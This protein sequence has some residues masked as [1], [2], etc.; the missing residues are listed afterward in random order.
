MLISLSLP[1]KTPRPLLFPTTQSSPRFVLLSTR[2]LVLSHLGSIALS[3]QNFGGL[4]Q[5]ATKKPLSEGVTSSCGHYSVF[6]PSTGNL[7]PASTRAR[8]VTQCSQCLSS[9]LLVLPCNSL[10]SARLHPI[11][12]PIPV[13][14]I[15]H[16]EIT[17][18]D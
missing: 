15:L 6:R 16:R 8:P 11:E 9:N 14:R 17:G 1:Q 4:L 7:I 2:A 5:D 3:H 18:R 10:S 13:Q 12:Y